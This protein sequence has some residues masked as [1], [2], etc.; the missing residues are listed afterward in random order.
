MDE[1]K[2]SLT[3]IKLR[4]PK[5]KWISEIFDD[6]PD[7]ELDIVNFFPY[8]FK[9]N[10]GNAIIEIKHYKIDQIIKKLK[11]HPS[12]FEFN[13]LNKKENQAK[14][15]IKTANPYLLFTVI[16]CGGIVDFPIKVRDNYILWTITSTRNQ[17][18]NILTKYDELKID[19]SILQ[20]SN[21]PANF[22]EEAKGL[23]FEESK[24]LDT[25]IKSG[26]FEVPRKIT[27]EELAN[28][29]GK[30]KSW[31]SELIRRIIKKKIILTA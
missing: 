29:L 25:A 31:T 17:L 18:D 15:N 21:T 14:I 12:I 4:V 9:K 7:I 11:V 5:E 28:N 20:F 8:D 6:Y 26:F 2:L 3:R 13:V 19:Y 24:I 10:I 22:E 27:L 30:S 23:S 16:K 1:D